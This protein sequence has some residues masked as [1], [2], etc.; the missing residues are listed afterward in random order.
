V[1]GGTLQF[2]L[3]GNPAGNAATDAAGNASRVVDVGLVAGVYAVSATFGGSS[4]YD[5]GAST[6]Q[7]TVTRMPSTVT[8]TGAV[9]GGPNKIVAI[10]AKLTDALGRPLDGKV[11]V[12]TLG[13]QTVS[14]TTANGGI[15]STT[16]KL[17]QHNGSYALTSVF[18]PAGGDA[19]KYFGAT[20]VTTF[21]IGSKLTSTGT[22][23]TGYSPGLSLP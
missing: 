5:G 3:G 14:A 22:A 19:S 12:F 2:T 13:T 16:L 21:I 17:N 11:I 8:Y 4:L 23:S 20:G 7:F 10:S 15:A 9:S 6:A 18:T 1:N